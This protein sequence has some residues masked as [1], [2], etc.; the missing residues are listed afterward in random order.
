MKTYRERYQPE[1]AILFSGC[2]INQMDNRL[3]HTPLYLAGMT[4]S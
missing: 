2:G 3:L 1:K 4:K